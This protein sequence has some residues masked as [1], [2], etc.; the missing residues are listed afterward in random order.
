MEC[1]KCFHRKH[2]SKSWAFLQNQMCTN[3]KPMAHDSKYVFLGVV[4]NVFWSVVPRSRRPP[5][6]V[7][8][9]R[10]VCQRRY[11][12]KVFSRFDKL[13]CTTFPNL[14]NILLIPMRVVCVDQ[15]SRTTISKPRTTFAILTHI[16]PRPRFFHFVF[17]FEICIL[18]GFRGSLTIREAHFC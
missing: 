6:E 17:T 12:C 11:F 4:F 1:S 7:Q 18:A 2:I 3:S 14:R 16:A 10:T 13:S 15:L 8:A 5:P 9:S